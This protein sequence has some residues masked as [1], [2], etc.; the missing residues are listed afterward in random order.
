MGALFLSALTASPIFNIYIVCDALTS[1]ASIH[2]GPV[3]TSTADNVLYAP[4]IT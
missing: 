2:T 3:N 1:A 4:Y